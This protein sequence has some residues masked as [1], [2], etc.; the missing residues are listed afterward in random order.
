MLRCG[1]TT[2]SCAAAA[3]K[4]AAEML[5]SGE[6]VTKTELLT[7]KG[8]RL[9]LD[10]T[11][12]VRG[13]GSASCAVKKDSGDDPDITN[14]ILVFSKV[15]LAESGVHISGGK[16]VGTVTKPGL[17]Q[18][19]GEAA[20]NSVPRKMIRDA[21]S[22]AAEKY[23]YKGGFEVEISIPEGE[24]LAART[25]NPRLGITG[26]ISVIGTSGIIEP[27]SSAALVDTIRTEIRMRKAEGHKS[28][29]FTLGNYGESFIEREL[30][31][32]LE[33]SVKISNFIGESVDI[34]L[35]YGFTG[36]LIIGHIGKLVK[37]GAGIM[38]THS[39]NA[40][41]RM[42]TLITCGLIAGAD[43]GTLLRLTDCATTDAA[44]DILDEA[45]YTEGTLAVLGERAGYH[46]EN[47][48]KGAA[49][50]AALMFSDRHGAR[51]ETAKT[52][53]LIKRISEEYNG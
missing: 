17:D 32:D 12:A 25:F 18:P 20:I 21:V 3:S 27:M 39:S 47:K 42:E 13:N 14:G 8:I 9:T 38:N 36:I 6:T 45:G 37:L 11:E 7:P 44:L 28:L 48:V 51:A 19:P 53:E 33:K 24:A 30:P 41:G 46:L 22:E 43:S 34:A 35:E 10:V 26:G 40:D 5:L 31:L 49:D 15:T 29:L 16:G 23:G 1:Y 50:I 4:A 52:Q 2:G